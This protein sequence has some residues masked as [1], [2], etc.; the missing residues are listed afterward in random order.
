[1]QYLEFPCLGLDAPFS[2]LIVLGYKPVD[3]SESE[4]W[5]SGLSTGGR[6]SNTEDLK[7]SM[8][9][10]HDR[11]VS[12]IGPVRPLGTHRTETHVSDTPILKADWA[13]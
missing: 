9:S 7:V 12:Q 10:A 1:M 5:T 11:N 8:E 4:S 3:Q 6:L 2:L 13:R